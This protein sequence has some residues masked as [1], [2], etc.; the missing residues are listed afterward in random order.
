MKTKNSRCSAVYY[1][2]VKRAGPQKANMA[3]AH[4]LI[5]IIYVMLRDKV[6]YEEL[7][8][9]YLGSREVSVDFWINKIRNMGYNV[10][11][12]GINESA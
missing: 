10:E 5:R 4:L 8:S 3:L 9:E 2:I 6:A 7:G 11:L 12:T 1:R